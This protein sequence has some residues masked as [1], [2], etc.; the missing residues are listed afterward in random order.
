[1]TSPG[2]CPLWRTTC[3]ERKRERSL[4]KKRGLYSWSS[5]LMEAIYEQKDKTK[6]SD[7]E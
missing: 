2:A 3:K 1:M 5:P 7:R 4:V 6:T